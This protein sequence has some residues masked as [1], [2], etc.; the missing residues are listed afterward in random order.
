M[1]RA[2]RISQP[3]MARSF[4][5]TAI[6]N[7]AVAQPTKRQFLCRCQPHSSPS[8]LSAPVGFSSRHTYPTST[9]LISTSPTLPKRHFPPT[10]PRKRVPAATSKKTQGKIIKDQALSD[11]RPAY[12]SAPS[13]SGEDMVKA[14]EFSRKSSEGSLESES[15]PFS[16]GA[17]PFANQ[18]EAAIEAS[19]R[20]TS[21]R[22]RAGRKDSR[23]DRANALATESKI[24][25]LQAEYLV[26]SAKW[27]S[28]NAKDVPI[29]SM[30]QCLIILQSKIIW[31]DPRYCFGI[32]R[33][34]SKE[35]A[36][37][38]HIR[39]WIRSSSFQVW[40]KGYVRVLMRHILP[41]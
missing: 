3:S 1:S 38:C 27:E 31:S 11:V 32:C 25:D 13:V 28:V 16:K 15:D 21:S 33:C 18:L 17:D 40:K 7:V 29:K 26:G 8:F 9:R 20:N 2:L 5:T 12:V 36:E 41:Y 6:A 24:P 35:Y 10:G 4:A 23:H 39:A 34:D 30:Y 22:N 37:S 19:L 14:I